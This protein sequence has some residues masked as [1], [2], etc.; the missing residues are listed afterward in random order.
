MDPARARERRTSPVDRQ[1]MVLEVVR[2]NRVI[3]PDPYPNRGA[4]SDLRSRHAGEGGELTEPKHPVKGAVL[5]RRAPGEP[6][7]A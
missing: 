5:P 7:P 3:H 4:S 2:F 1:C 6:P